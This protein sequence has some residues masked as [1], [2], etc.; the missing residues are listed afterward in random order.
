M[1]MTVFGSCTSIAAVFNATVVAPAPPLEAR[2]PKILPGEER[3]RESGEAAMFLRR[4]TAKRTE[5]ISD[6]ELTEPF[7]M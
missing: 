2:K 6:W 1:A 3:H 4:S 5:R 7:A